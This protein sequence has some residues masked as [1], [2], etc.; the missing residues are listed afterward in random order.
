MCGIFYY[1]C[2]SKISVEKYGKLFA[3]FA[4][5][6]H[7][8]P[9]NSQFQRCVGNNTHSVIGFH[10][11]AVNG[12][13]PSGNQPFEAA[14][15][16]LVC[17]GEIYNFR[18][19]IARY[20]LEN[21]CTSESDCEIIIHLYKRIGMEAML[22]ALDGVFAMV[23]YDG[24]TN[25]T[26]VARDPF[27]VRSL[28]IGT[29]YLESLVS[30]SDSADN[31]SEH[32]CESFSVA[33]EMK[34]LS[35]CAPNRVCQFPA[36]CYYEHDNSDSASRGNYFAYY[37]HVEVDMVNIVNVRTHTSFFR[38]RDDN[39]KPKSN[40]EESEF[41][42]SLPKLRNLLTNAVRK[43]M[44]SDRPIGALLSG[45]L[46]SSLVTAIMCRQLRERAG[47]GSPLLLNTY[48]IG[49]KGSIDLMWAK[50][51]SE[52]LGTTHHE[53]C[54]SE[55]EFLDAIEPTIAQIESYDTTTVR[56]SVGNYL[57]S[58]YISRTTDDVVIYCGDMSDEIFGSYRGFVKATGDTEFEIENER[59]V[60]DVRYFDLLRSDKSISGCG[61]E[62]RVPFA[63]KELLEYVMSLSPRH[64]RFNDGSYIE[65]SVLRAAF[66]TL[67][68][69]NAFLPSDALWRR[70]EAF[71]DGVSAQTENAGIDGVNTAE[72]RTWI[73]MIRDYVNTKVS[74]E[75]YLS[76][77]HKF[78]HNTPYDKE[79]YYYRKVY[80]RL[81]PGRETLI[82]YFWR[83]PF[84]SELD[85]SA[86]LL[87]T[88]KPNSNPHSQPQLHS[89]P[90]LSPIINSIPALDSASALT[91]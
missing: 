91:L 60:Q 33:S 75:E 49:L 18:E 34:S 19:L 55:Q 11:L 10:R 79:S 25:R 26:Y 54:L 37:K 52:F 65:K 85:P 64:K 48:S 38:V 74:N 16:K 68:A 36:G 66:D 17:N 35:H 78:H 73:D 23:L 88:L 29:E 20:S 80:E 9:D 3:D 44:M 22:N 77:R 45:G 8:G 14:R 67:D 32:C 72:Q 50:R 81:Y 31:K 15:C 71:S 5:M 41:A 86:R 89:S 13:A 43:R 42:L 70:K 59:M 27:G 83:Q 61:L 87:S 4:K 28:F 84:C 47:S 90:Y 58:K 6:S 30:E 2:R 21:V 40:K 56:A 62:A 1:Q 12:I 63:D 7:R 51:V 46:D 69:A 39:N 57:V 24:D 53:V 76:E 82:P